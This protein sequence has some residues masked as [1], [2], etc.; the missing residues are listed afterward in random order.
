MF[1]SI[2]FLGIWVVT[3]PLLTAAV[4]GETLTS[5]F[6]EKVANISF[7]GLFASISLAGGILE[8]QPLVFS[9]PC[10]LPS[11]PPAAGNQSLTEVLMSIDLTNY[12]LDMYGYPYFNRN[13][14]ME[15]AS[16]L[17]KQDWENGFVTFFDLEEY[18]TPNSTISTTAISGYT[19]YDV[20]YNQ[21]QY[22]IE[23][24][25]FE[26][27]WAEAGPAYGDMILNGTNILNSFV[28]RPG[29]LA[30]SSEI[31]NTTV[32]IDAEWMNSL[33][34]LVPF[35]FGNTSVAEILVQTSNNLW[36]PQII[37]PIL[38]ASTMAAVS[39][40]FVICEDD[41]LFC[42]QISGNPS[43][44][45]EYDYNR[46]LTAE[47]ALPGHQIT[48]RATLHAS[49]TAYRFSNSW[50]IILGFVFLYLHVALVLIHLA[51]IVLGGFWTS[52]AWSNLGD[53]VALAL[54]SP[55]VQGQSA[56]T[57]ALLAEMDAGVSSTKAWGL[58]VR[59]R[60]NNTGGQDPSEKDDLR[61]E[62]V[63]E[64]PCSQSRGE[65]RDS[66]TGQDD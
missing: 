26:C 66:E 60:E 48:Y 57:A 1:Y 28:A 20:L 62:M 14:S 63:L 27:H 18:M 50:L 11:M 65:D 44:M 3:C 54:R 9:I 2:D 5:Q 12:C 31:Y 24:I 6:T 29:N 33:L 53:F 15:T 42:E 52:N 40:S 38:V 56:T 64:E 13:L 46:N 34:T 55:P 36:S 43:S 58:V 47:A 4:F 39:Y 45:M 25:A 35:D 22:G 7:D 17:A 61:L 16:I 30:Q 8:R 59:I 32:K 37:L 23:I 49:I 21:I 51:I 10:E 41:N 19:W